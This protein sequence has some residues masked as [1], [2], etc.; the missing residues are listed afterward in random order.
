M[1]TAQ[2]PNYTDGKRVYRTLREMRLLRDYA[3]R[4]IPHMNARVLARSHKSKRA[5]MGVVMDQRATAVADLAKALFMREEWVRERQKSEVK[6]GDALMPPDRWKKVERYAR[7]VVDGRVAALDKGIERNLAR[8]N[9]LKDEGKKERGQ[10]LMTL[11]RRILVLRTQRNRMLRCKE[12]VDHLNGMP[13]PEERQA[14]WSDELR[15]LVTARKR[16]I[17]AGKKFQE[18]SANVAQEELE[19]MLTQGWKTPRQKETAKRRTK[20]D[21]RAAGESEAGKQEEDGQNEIISSYFRSGWLPR[22]KKEIKEYSKGPYYRAD[23]WVEGPHDSLIEHRRYVWKVKGTQ[24]FSDTHHIAY[25]RGETLV[26]PPSAIK[27]KWLDIK[28]AEYAQSWPN[29]VYHAHI[30]LLGYHTKYTMPHPDAGPIM[31]VRTV[32]ERVQRKWDGV[33]E[34]VVLDGEA[35]EEPPPETKERNEGGD[36]RKKEEQG[37]VKEGEKKSIWS[38]VRSLPASIMGSMSR[39]RPE[40]RL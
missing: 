40:A 5:M 13:V 19:A 14:Q 3:W 26:L 11:K 22:T 17:A 4:Q 15:A 10:E 8:L 7:G 27:I 37:D 6:M 23:G 2:D 39:A 34:G 31:E 35:S 25:P 24:Y 29:D 33:E 36:G 38:R 21:I 28:D 20:A 18:Q 16:K 32:P 1:A 9:A 12:A 30:G